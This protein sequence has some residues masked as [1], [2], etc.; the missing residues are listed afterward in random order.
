MTDPERTRLDEDARRIRN[1]RRWG[2]YLAERQWGTVREDYSETGDCWNY[3]PHDHARSRAYRWG[4][5]GLLGICDRECR[6]CFSL[7]LWNGVDPILKER[8]FGLTGPEGNHGEDVKELYYYLEATPTASYLKALYKYPQAAFPYDRLVADNAKRGKGDR[9]L[10]LEDTGVFDRGY[11]DVTAEYAKAGV[12]DI[13]VRITIANRGPEAATLHLLPTAWLRN[14]WSWGRTGEGYDPKG[15]LSRVGEA[16]VRIEQPTLGHYR[17]DCEGKPELLFTDNET[18]SE[19]LFGVP[20]PSAHVKDAFHRRVVNGEGAAI[21]RTGSGTKCAAWYVLAVPAGQSRVIRLRLAPDGTNAAPFADHDALFAK[22]IAESDHYHR[23][24]RNTPMT[25]DERAIVRQADAGLVWS[26]QFYHY[27]VEHWLDGDPAQPAPPEAR[28]H[29]RNRSW[30]HLWARDIISMPDAWEY[31]WFAAWDLAFH[32]VAMARFDPEFAKYQLVLLCREWYVH[33]NG[34]AARVRVRVQRCQPAGPRVGGVARVRA[35]RRSRVR[36]RPRVP[37]AGVRQVPH[38][39]HV[40][41]QSRGRRG[42]EPIHRRLP[43]PRQ[44]R[45]VRSQQAAARRRRARAGGCHGVDGVLLHDDAADGARAR[46]DRE[47]RTPI[48]R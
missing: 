44:H 13:L 47:C 33:P 46:E 39:L 36:L 18:N 20:N 31:P 15:Q 32:C 25:D 29:G 19:R 43:R 28:K 21:A 23:V 45:R 41:G 12:D 5:D 7:A 40:V 10:E 16:S 34:A 17:L 6:V 37:R 1:W 48:S 14:T 24:V 27:I 9:E 3:L 8:L 2:P 30:Q 26:R 35:R 42:R 38:Q 11:W 4:E 22:R